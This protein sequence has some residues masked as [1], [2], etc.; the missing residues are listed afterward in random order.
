VTG[1]EERYSHT[2]LADFAAN[3]EGAQQAYR[4]VRGLAKAQDAS[5]VRTLDRRFAA[6]EDELARYGSVEKGFRGYDSL[7]RS[8]VKALSDEV[9][10]VSEPLS[11]LTATVLKEL[12]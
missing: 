6:L 9:N 1:E 11:E 10:A 7:S 8:D 2:D 4:T 12:G 5:L 3:V